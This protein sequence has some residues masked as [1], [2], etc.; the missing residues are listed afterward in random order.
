MEVRGSQ[1]GQLE[2]TLASRGLSKARATRIPAFSF[3][4]LRLTR[5]SGQGFQA[6][7]RRKA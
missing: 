3:L 2:G 6:D 5:F 4:F 1:E 7:Q